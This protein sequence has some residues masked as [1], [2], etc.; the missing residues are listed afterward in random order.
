MTGFTELVKRNLRVYFRDR[1]AVFFSL[2]SMVIVIA[3]ML[4]F[5]GDM[6]ID[7]IINILS[8]FPGRDAEK[9]KANAEM[10][11]LIWTAGGIIS[12]NA[13]TVTLAVLSSM[14]KDRTSGVLNSIYTAPISRLAISA[15]YVTASWV[16]SVIICAITLAISEIYCIINGAEPF[17]AAAHFKLIGM[18]AVNSFAYSSLMYL[19][20]MHAKTEG[21][22]SG[23]GTV[24]GTL[25]GF[26]GGIYLPIGTLSDGIANAMK[27]LPVIYGSAAFRDIMTKDIVAE[28]FEGAPAELVTEYKQ[29]MG[30][31]LTVGESAVSSGMCVIILAV[32]GVV[33]LAA[34][35]FV[36]AKAKRADR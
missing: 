13:V 18:I 3:L 24:I 6:N 12:I 28:L 30:I 15:S 26:L 1:S 31:E 17:S 2:L 36:S 29:A 10:L 4:F 23:L 16:A 22:W 27:C 34:G 21:A 9:D 14:I 32:C 5:L 20:A 33:F 11:V 35:A 25:V 8:A 19:V 7:S